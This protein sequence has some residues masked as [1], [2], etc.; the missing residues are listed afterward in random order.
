MSGTDARL[1][2]PV[3][4]VN[5][6]MAILVIGAAYLVR[7]GT[8]GEPGWHAPWWLTITT[9]LLLPSMAG[10][11]LFVVATMVAISRLE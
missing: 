7:I 3:P 11:W 5:D 6:L 8:L 1:R 10:A 9:D 4:S 2:G